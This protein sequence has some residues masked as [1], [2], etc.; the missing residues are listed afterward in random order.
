MQVCPEDYVLDS[1]LTGQAYAYCVYKGSFVMKD[2][3]TLVLTV[4]PLTA[5]TRYAWS[6]FERFKITGLTYSSS[7]LKSVIIFQ[8]P[9]TFIVKINN[10][11]QLNLDI[12]NTTGTLQTSTLYSTTAGTDGAWHTFCASL[13]NFKW[14]LYM[15]YTLI[16]TVT[17]QLLYYNAT[18]SGGSQISL[19]LQNAY[20]ST[21]VY[22]ADLAVFGQPM[23][24]YEFQ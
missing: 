8:L 15:D 24:N 21:M 18:S 11:N 2:L 12:Y 3:T 1:S 7:V 6:I 5:V 19:D 23:T 9:S 22:I 14:Y 16:A 13:F 20:T 10:Q 17:D 4:K